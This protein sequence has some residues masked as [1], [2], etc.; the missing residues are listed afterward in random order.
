MAGSTN[1]EELDDVRVAQLLEDGDFP[2]NP[3]QVGGILDHRLVQDLYCRL[4]FCYLV[5]T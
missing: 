2:V 3:L 5:G 4:L 1:I